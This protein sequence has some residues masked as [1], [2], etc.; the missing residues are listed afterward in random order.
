MDS[1]LWVLQFTPILFETGCTH[2]TRPPKG[3][4][5]KLVFIELAPLEPER[6]LPAGAHRPFDVGSNIFPNMLFHANALRQRSGVGVM[7]C[8]D[9]TQVKHS[10]AGQARH[11]GEGEAIP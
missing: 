2:R 8:F 11:A 3:L 9:N 5:G 7:F 4:V 10:V 1:S 6:D